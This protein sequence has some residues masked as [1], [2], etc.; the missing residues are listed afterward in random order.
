MHSHSHIGWIMKCTGL[1]SIAFLLV[2]WIL[3]LRFGVAICLSNRLSIVFQENQ[4]EFYFFPPNRSWLTYN[5]CWSGE[6]SRIEFLWPEIDGTY[7]FRQGMRI[8]T[9]DILMLPYWIPIVFA[10]LPTSVLFYK[11]RHRLSPCHCPKC[12]YNLTGN[13]SGVCSECGAKITAEQKSI[14]QSIA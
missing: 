8:K 1:F 12:G 6:W 14:P 4:M 10:V 11:D 3:T 13:T 7:I 9:S 5:E 2:V